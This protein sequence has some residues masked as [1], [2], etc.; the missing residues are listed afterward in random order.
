LIIEGTISSPGKSFRA[1]NNAIYTEY[2]VQIEKIIS[3][4]ASTKTIKLLVE[5][6]EVIE[7]GIYIGT[8]T[9]HGINLR[10]NAISIIFAQPTDIGISPES[11]MVIEQVCYNLKNQVIVTNHLSEYYTNINDLYRDISIK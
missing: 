11:F 9:P 1:K 7:N 4:N 2:N 6:G 10:F 5:G 8:G 3:G